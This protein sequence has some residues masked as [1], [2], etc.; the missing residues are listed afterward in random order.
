[1]SAEKAACVQAEI[2][3][4]KHAA[5]A[6]KRYQLN[7]LFIYKLRLLREVMAAQQDACSYT[8]HQASS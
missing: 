4:E 8:V 7:R 3:E 2:P 5:G 1:M 6:S